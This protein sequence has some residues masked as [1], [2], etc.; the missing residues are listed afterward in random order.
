MSKRALRVYKGGGASWK[1]C[2]GDRGQLPLTSSLLSLSST[3]C[4]RSE[5]RDRLVAPVLPEGQE[6]G[7][8]KCPAGCQSV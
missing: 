8:W 3:L 6:A 4:P 7:V 2:P 1:P 5:P